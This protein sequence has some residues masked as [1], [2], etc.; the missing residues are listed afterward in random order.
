[1]PQFWLPGRCRL[2][3]Q[4]NR[5][6]LRY[7]RDVVK[8]RQQARHIAALLD[9]DPQ[10]Q[11]RIATATSEIAR[12]AFRYAKFGSVEFLL[13]M[14]APQH[15]VVCVDDKGAGITNLREVLDGNYKS[16]TGMGLG[17]IGTRRLMEKFEIRTGP[18][19]TSVSFQA[20]L[21]RC[22]HVLRR[23][24]VRQLVERLSKIELEDP[25]EEVE[26]QNQELLNTLANLRAR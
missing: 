24:Q 1:M 5:I 9:F 13:E 25:F 7:E 10:E 3:E 14:E 17:L 8:A 19:G 26:R 23:D 6:A 21:P 20:V 2:R 16:A 22:S 15:L 4:L 18:E 12:N 11:T